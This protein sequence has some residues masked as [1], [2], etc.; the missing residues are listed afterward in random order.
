MI[1]AGDILILTTSL[2]RN[3]MQTNLSKAIDCLVVSNHRYR[4]SL[5]QLDQQTQRLK[6]S[7]VRLG[8]VI[9]YKESNTDQANVIDLNKYKARKYAN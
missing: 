6:R 2:Q 4:E 9:Q 5:N 3:N 8:R 7:L 1:H